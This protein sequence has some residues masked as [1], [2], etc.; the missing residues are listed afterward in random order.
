VVVCENHQLYKAETSIISFRI[1]YYCAQKEDLER[2][3]KH[4]Q[5]DQS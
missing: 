4:Y 2:G 5:K 1:L 3:C